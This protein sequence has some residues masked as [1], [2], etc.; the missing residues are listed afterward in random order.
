MRRTQR[1]SSA[2]LS[3]N[4]SCSEN[5]ELA[6]ERER[7]SRKNNV[8]IHG[9]EEANDDQATKDKVFFDKL[10]NDLT[11]AKVEAKSVVRIGQKTNGKKRP[12][13]I[14]L[15]TTSEKE[16]I[17]DN[18]RNLKDKG[19]NGISIKEDHTITERGMIKDFAEKAKS[20]NEKEAPDSDKIWVVRG[21]PKN[22]LFLKKVSTF[23]R[24]QPPAE[25]Q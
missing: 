24:T 14:T 21:S 25:T 7:N 9:C 10:I 5:E 4:R 23:K 20:A 15:T 18:L 13:K 12:I 6:E 17:M 22:G 1:P 11:I 2:E 19:Y 8:I 3:R 16:K